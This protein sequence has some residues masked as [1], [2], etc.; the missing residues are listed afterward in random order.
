MDGAGKRA[1]RPHGAPRGEAAPPT[2]AELVAACI[3][4]AP[5]AWDAFVDRFGGLLFHVADRTAR[6]RGTTLGAADR[7]DAVAAVLLELLRGDAAALRAFAGRSSL[8]TYLTVITRRVTVRHLLAA[9][10]GQP[11]G[12]DPSHDPRPAVRDREEVEALLGS[13]DEDEA[14]LVRLHHL[15]GRSYGEISRATGLPLGSIGPA[16]SK[17]RD[18]MRAAA[19]R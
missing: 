13:L 4:G 10:G 17:A 16:L 19:Q 12:S 11:A 6:Q 7:D 18:K 9:A 14:R 3:A 8:A 5:G 2:D 1:V 15:E